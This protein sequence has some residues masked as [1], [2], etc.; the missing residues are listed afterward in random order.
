M[1]VDEYWI[2]D[3]ATESVRVH[4]LVNDRYEETRLTRGTCAALRTPL[5]AGLVLSLDDVFEMPQT[6]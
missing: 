2:V 6:R 1:R 3:P 5:L 4:T